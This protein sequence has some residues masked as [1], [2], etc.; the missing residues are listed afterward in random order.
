MDAASMHRLVE[1]ARVGRLATVDAAGRPHAVP[2]CF[3][4]LGEAA[5]TAVDRK[6]K[7]G[8][9]L[10]RVANIE[11]TGRA[12]LL[13]DAYRE[14]WSELWWVRLD[15]RARVV[16][17]PAESGRALAVLVAKYR[18]YAVEPPPGPVLALDVER[19]SGWSA[20]PGF[21]TSTG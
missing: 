3:V 6:P 16:D 13:V 20:S 11:A 5:Y 8:T 7:R 4:L 10:R 2:I 9:R 21:P 19:W 18:Q 15:A 14:D 1:A 12:C 17:D